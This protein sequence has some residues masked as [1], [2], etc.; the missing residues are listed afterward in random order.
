MIE[1]KDLKKS[2]G[3]Q[4]V[5]NGVNFEIED[6]KITVILGKSGVG[7]SVLLSNIIGLTIPDSGSIFYKDKDITKLNLKELNKIRKN[8][9]VLF[10]D[11]ALFDSLNVFE[12]IAFPLIEHKTVKNKKEIKQ[13][14]ADMLKLVGLSD[15][16]HKMPSELSGG[17]RKR[18]ALARAII[19]NPE[20][21][22]FD[23]PTTGL[24]PVSA[25]SIANLIKDMQEKLSTTCFI[26]SHD[27]SL[28]FNIAHKI[29][30]L[31]SGKIVDFGDR[32]H[33]LNSDNNIVKNFINAY[34][35]GD[36]I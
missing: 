13:R 1:V 26:I 21:V 16:E 33:F 14:V 5:L 12:N 35:L 23:E 18:V 34:S 22:F 36:T 15:I 25:M 2:F 3:T 19:T 17:M 32:N 30:L 10:Q 29:G 24:D 20:V 9:G 31:D 8:F 4:T 28:T 7:K 11:A 6:K 27:L